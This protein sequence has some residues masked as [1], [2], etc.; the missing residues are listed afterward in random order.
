MKFYVVLSLIIIYVS[1]D[2]AQNTEEIP[3]FFDSRQEWPNCIPKVYDQGTCGAC[4][5]VSTATTFSARFCIKNKLSKIINFSPQYLVNCLKGCKGEFPDVVWEYIKTNGITTDKCQSY[6]KN[7]NICSTKC[8]SKS[9]SF[10]KYYSGELKFLEDEI[11]IKKEI[12]KNGPVTSMMDLYN[13][14]YNYQSGIYI[15]SNGGTKL[16]FHAISIIGWGEEDNNK[17]WI[18]QDSY[19]TSRG[20]SGYMRIKIGDESGAGATAF[21]DEMEGNYIDNN[22]NNPKNSAI[23]N[24]HKVSFLKNYNKLLLFF[25]ILL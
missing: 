13:D 10:Q 1:K 11:S 23:S 21:C 17:Y 20:E 4:Y 5:A 7:E 2:N 3:D 14:Y 22:I 6:K 15:H 16:G 24:Y 18:I 19:G 25:Y 9:D 12:M 8:D